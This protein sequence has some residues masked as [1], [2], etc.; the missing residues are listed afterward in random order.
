MSHAEYPFQPVP[1]T[2][3]KV[4]DDFWLP[5]IETNRRVTIPYDFQK[6]EETGRIDNFVKAAGKL[7]GPH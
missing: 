5:R 1:F 6:C 4:Q 3:V 2:Q 7:P